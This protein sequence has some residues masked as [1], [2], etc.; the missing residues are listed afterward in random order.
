MVPSETELWEK[1]VKMSLSVR[2][3]AQQRV[4]SSH[5]LGYFKEILIKTLSK[6]V[7]GISRV[8][9]WGVG[10]AVTGIPSERAVWTKPLRESVTLAEGHTQP[11]CRE[12]LSRKN[13]LSPA[14][15]LLPGLPVGWTEWKLEG[16]WFVGVHTGHISGFRELVDGE[17]GRETRRATQQTV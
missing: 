6:D 16:R 7:S 12:G 3:P 10:R 2:V 9:G 4:N 14:L 1:T 5:K 13:I 15:P 8:G 11:A 17:S